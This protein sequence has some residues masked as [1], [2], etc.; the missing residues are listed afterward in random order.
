MS[1]LY[2]ESERG[3]H[4]MRYFCTGCGAWREGDSLKLVV[5]HMEGYKPGSEEHREVFE[6]AK[7]ERPFMSRHLETCGKR[8]AWVLAIYQD[9]PRWSQLDPS[10]Q[11]F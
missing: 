9:D 2:P 6:A 1:E 11:E 10:K 3:K 4:Q 7:S 5:G 8:G